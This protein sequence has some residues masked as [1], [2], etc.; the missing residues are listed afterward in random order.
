MLVAVVLTFPGVVPNVLLRLGSLTDT[1]LPWLGLLVPV[2]LG[3]ALWRRSLLALV[4]VLLPA[5][6]WVGA[7]GGLMR[8]GERADLVVVQHNVSDENADPAAT[9]RALM[10]PGPDLIG[11]EEVTP[12]ALPAYEAAFAQRYPHH[13]VQGT[14]GLWSRHPLAEARLLDIKPGGLDADW[15][16]GLRALARTPHGD[17]AV[18]VTH[19]PSLRPGPRGFDTRRRD[20]SARKLGAALAAEPVRRVVLI[21]DLNATL[22][23]RGLRPVGDHVTGAATGFAFSWPAAAPVA[24]IDQV[25]VRRG[26]VTAVR[27]LPRTG[28]DHLPIAARV[29][30]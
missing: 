11:V 30:W 13:T 5:V 27:T 10:R 17:V 25:M 23:D 12:E 15:R 7:F 4:V 19:L 28:S 18:Y 6:A 21:G 9:A 20:D 22:D 26:N 29:R 14:V 16:R 8:S 2:L 3:V 1:F 24:R